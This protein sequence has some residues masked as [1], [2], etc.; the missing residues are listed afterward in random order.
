MPH[1]I[2]EHSQNFDKLA[3]TQ[4][5]YA[6]VIA[7]DL[8]DAQNVKVRSSSYDNYFSGAGQQDFVH[9]CLRILDGR[10]V[11]QRTMLSNCVLLELKKLGLTGVSISAEVI[12][13]EKA[14]YAKVVV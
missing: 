3:L 13:M 11:E 12:D 5:V 10:T 7:A 9:V 6:G 2:I 8:F 4:A 1:C 14:S